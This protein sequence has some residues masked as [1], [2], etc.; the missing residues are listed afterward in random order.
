MLI[1]KDKYLCKNYPHIVFLCGNKF[2]GKNNNDKRSILKSFIENNIPN[3]YAVILE[4]NFMFKKTNQEYLSYDEIF[5]KNLFQVEQLASIFADKII[6]IH[7]TLSTAAELGMFAR[8][9]NMMKKICLLVPDSMAIEENKITSFIKLAYL[10][11][12]TPDIQIGKQI[13]YYPDMEV[14]R[15]SEFKSDYRTGFHNNEIGFNLG[16]KVLDFVVS[17][18][19]DIEIVFC[20][21]KYNIPQKY[22]NKITYHISQKAK[23]IDIYLNTCILRIQLLSLFFVDEFKKQIWIDKPIKDHVNYIKDFYKNILLNTICHIE[24][25]NVNNYGLSVTLSDTICDLNQAIGYFVYMLQATNLISL[26]GSA[27]AEDD[28]IR[29]FRISNELKSYKPHMGEYIKKCKTTAFGRL[30]I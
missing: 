8:D 30:G 16:R 7:E 11:S 12:K 2:V 5:L 9:T 17:K 15:F 29:R 13:V 20:K 28:S 6:I 27:E 19:T 24:G 21:N 23:Q 25:L 18:Q 26:E 14:V 10:N 22:I 1:F 3:F 4:E